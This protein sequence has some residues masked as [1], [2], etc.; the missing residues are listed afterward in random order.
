MGEELTTKQLKFAGWY[1]SHKTEIYK[2]FLGLLVAINLA[3]WGLVSYKFVNYFSLTDVHEEMLAELTKNKID[4]L[5]FH[6]Y[7]K[8]LDL[9]VAKSVFLFSGALSQ[10]EKF[11][12]DF[13][14]V[15]ENPN[16]EWLIPAVEYYFLWDDGQTEVKRSFI[17]PGEKKNLTALGQKTDKKLNEVQFV[18][19]KIRWQRVNSKKERPEILSKLSVKDI[20][21]DYAIAEDRMVAIPKISFKIKNLSIYSF[22]QVDFTIILY[23]GSNIV[24]I[25]TLPTKQWRSN[26]ERKME[27][28]WP[29]IPQHSHIAVM[30]EINPF[31]PKI[32]MPVY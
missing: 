1:L 22:W 16:E 27:L 20:N 7:F 17:L 8:P 25:N 18:F 3:L 11:K 29:N 32:F 14:A 10:T 23:Q 19:S 6:E 30:V 2:I 12:Y 26:E 15:I 24:G 28:M 5:K 31:D 4:Y 13:V 21:L 9:I